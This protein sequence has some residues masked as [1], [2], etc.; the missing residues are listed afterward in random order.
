ML[1]AEEEVKEG[2]ISDLHGNVSFLKQQLVAVS[3]EHDGA[4]SDDF[5]DDED[6]SNDEGDDPN[7]SQLGSFVQGVR[8]GPFGVTTAVVGAVSGK[9]QKPGRKAKQVALDQIH[10]SGRKGYR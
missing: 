3:E 8:R 6:G 9:R 2:D 1:G 10:G 7:A 4:A 5:Y